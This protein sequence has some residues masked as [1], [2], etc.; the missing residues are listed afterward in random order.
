MRL[1]FLGEPSLEAPL[2]PLGGAQQQPAYMGQLGSVD[3]PAFVDPEAA[4]LG[5][6]RF[7]SALAT[8]PT[9]EALKGA[10]SL[11]GDVYAGRTDP[12]SD[13]GIGRATDLAGLAMTGGVA[14]TGPGGVALGSGPIRNS[15]LPM[16]EAARRIRARG[17]GYADEPFFRGDGGTASEYPSGG[18][19]SRDPEYANG[20][21]KQNGQ[22]AAREFQLNL[23]NAFRDNEPVP[24]SHYARLA[25]AAAQR[26]PKLAAELVDD[27]A[28]GKSLGWFTEFARRNPDHP[29]QNGALVR[30]QIDKNSSDPI[31]VFRDA[32]FDA[33]DSGRDVRKL[34]AEGIRHKD[35]VFDP[36]KRDSRDI[37]ATMAAMGI[38]GAA[39]APDDQR[40]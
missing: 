18:H 36:G 2:S 38:M 15:A 30:Q 9:I 7:L 13:E 12:M 28:P 4:A 32:G 6:A 29:T 5:K 8:T 16:D 11:P 37:F 27:I 33:L 25:N 34:T 23:E 31:G 3:N 1:P 22:D 20:F 14:G 40:R 19:W 17:M 39:A 24:A 21:A 10:V 35:A 26:D